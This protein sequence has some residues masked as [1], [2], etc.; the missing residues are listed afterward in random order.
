MQFTTVLTL[1]TISLFQ[2]GGQGRVMLPKPNDVNTAAIATFQGTL[3]SADKKQL[4]LAVE[5]NESLKMFVTAKTRFIRDGATAKPSDFHGGETVMV[6]AARDVK[7]NLLAVK[8]E[9]AAHKAEQPQ[10]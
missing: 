1:L 9:Y 7:L 3:K 8:V 2:Y 10:R 6:E 5:D 4:I